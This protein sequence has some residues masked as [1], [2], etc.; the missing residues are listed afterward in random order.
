MFYA[1]KNVIFYCFMFILIFFLSSKKW[2]IDGANNRNIIVRN[3]VNGFNKPTS[4]VINSI[5]ANRIK[6]AWFTWISSLSIAWGGYLSLSIA[7]FW[8]ISLTFLNEWHLST[9]HQLPYSP[10]VA[11]V[12]FRQ[13]KTSSATLQDSFEFIFPIVGGGCLTRFD[14]GVWNECIS[15]FRNLLRFMASNFYHSLKNSFLWWR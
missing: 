10:T 2:P 4:F 5:L 13:D 1:G 3:N 11:V 9:L 15:I 12:C 7:W 14:R 8:L 6:I